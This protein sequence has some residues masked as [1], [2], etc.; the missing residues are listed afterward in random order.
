MDYGLVI[1]IGLGLG[2]GL[3]LRLWFVHWSFDGP[4]SDGADF[5]G[6]GFDREPAKRCKENLHDFDRGDLQNG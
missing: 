2:Y 6:P 5:V 4:G 3:G 1:G